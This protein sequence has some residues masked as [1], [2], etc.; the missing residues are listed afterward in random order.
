MNRYALA[1]AAIAAASVAV[2]AAAQKPPIGQETVIPFAANGGIRNFTR[3]ESADIVY[4]QSRTNDWYRVT[5][6]GPCLAADTLDT[7]LYSTDASGTLD[8]FSQ[9]RSRRFPNQTCGVRTIVR[10]EPP[11]NR[12]K[13]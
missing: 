3:G 8:R 1:L 10:S 12:P 5:L 2:P 13:G 7:L 9:L 11:P 6:T 4:L